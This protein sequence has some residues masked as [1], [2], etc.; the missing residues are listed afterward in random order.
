[1]RNKMLSNDHEVIGFKKWMSNTVFI[2]FSGVPLKLK[3]DLY[4][5]LFITKRFISNPG[6]NT[7]RWKV[8]F[9]SNKTVDTVKNLN[10]QSWARVPKVFSRLASVHIS[11]NCSCIPC[12]AHSLRYLCF[13]AFTSYIYI[14]SYLITEFEIS[15]NSCTDVKHFTTHKDTL[16]FVSLTHPT[17]RVRVFFVPSTTIT[18]AKS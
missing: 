8:N 9:F 4:H 13:F 12:F 11:Q 5:H 3:K 6:R 7:R 18:S 17:F 16:N 2:H 1:M 15:L 10:T 14:Y